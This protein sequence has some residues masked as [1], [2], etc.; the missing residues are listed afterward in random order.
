VPAA[1][2]IMV[3]VPASGKSTLC[4]EW[5]ALMMVDAVVCPDVIRGDVNGAPRRFDPATEPVVWERARAQVDAYLG[6]GMRVV[7]DATNL[8]PGRR[9]VW[10]EVARSWGIVPRADVVDVLLEDALERNMARPLE[11]RVPFEVFWRF[12]QEFKLVGADARV[13]HEEGFAPVVLHGS[14]SPEKILAWGLQQSPG[15]V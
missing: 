1:L 15:G 10:L 14:H 13:L 4:A 5:L 8:T 7:L 3:G 6:S 12:W 9:A 11:Q 2:V